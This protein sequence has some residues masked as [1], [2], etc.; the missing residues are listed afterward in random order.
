[1]V[2]RPARVLLPKRNDSVFP[3]GVKTFANE[4]DSVDVRSQ[5][6]TQLGNTVAI[7][8]IEPLKFKLGCCKRSCN[9]VP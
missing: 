9:E 5:V 4:G 1:M 6:L 2:R 3:D 8:C 7:D